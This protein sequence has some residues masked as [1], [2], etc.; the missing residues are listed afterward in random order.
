MVVDK[1]Q[2]TRVE[3]P[4]LLCNHVVGDERALQE[5]QSSESILA[6]SLAG[7]VATYRLKRT[8][9]HWWAGRWSF[10]KRIVPD[11]VLVLVCEGEDR[12]RL[13]QLV[14]DSGVADHI[15]F[16]LGLTQE[17]LFACYAHCDVFALASRGEGFG[18]AFLEA[19]ACAKPAIG[20]A[21]GGTPHVIEDSVT[22]L[23]VPHGDAALL[24]SGLESLLVDPSRACE[25]GARGRERVQAAYTFER[26]QTGLNRA[27]EDVLIRQQSCKARMTRNSAGV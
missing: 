16:L 23:L 1:P 24:S 19:M 3:E 4:T 10:E 14:R 11:M 2:S 26:F 7:D 22:G 8:Q 20:G 27:M 5:R 15:H 13:E 17:E 9:R 25:M 18:L 12:P 6:S 21:H